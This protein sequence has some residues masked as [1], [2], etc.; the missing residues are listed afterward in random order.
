MKDTEEPTHAEHLAWC[1][2]RALECVERGDLVESFNSMA[3]DLQKH[4]Q[5]AGHSALE[6][7]VMLLLNGHLNTAE[8]MTRF[9]EGFN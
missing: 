4:A 7:G 6:L 8:A 3:S 5:T 1:K 9:I 2:E